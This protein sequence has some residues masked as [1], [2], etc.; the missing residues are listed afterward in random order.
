MLV[1]ATPNPDSVAETFVRMVPSVDMVRFT[2][3]GTES[4]MYAIRAARVFTGRKGLVKIGFVITVRLWF[5]GLAAAA[6]P[7]GLHVLGGIHVG[8]FRIDTDG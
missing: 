5:E 6:T 4:L 7:A 2:N 3:S 8:V 1:V